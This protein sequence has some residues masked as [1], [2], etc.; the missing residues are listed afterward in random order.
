[1]TSSYDPIILF[2]DV[3]SSEMK[4]SVSMK[5]CTKKFTALPFLMGK[6]WNQS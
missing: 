3:Y 4:S 6:M 1:M 5:T 2:L